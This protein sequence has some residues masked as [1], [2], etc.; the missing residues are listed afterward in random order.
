MLTEKKETETETE[1]LGDWHGQRTQNF[2]LLKLLF[3]IKLELHSAAQD[4]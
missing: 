2:T 3:M 1:S 4:P